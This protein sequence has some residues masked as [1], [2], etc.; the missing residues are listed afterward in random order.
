MATLKELGINVGVN[1]HFITIQNVKVPIAFTMESMEHITDVY[2]EDYFVFEQDL[3]KMLLDKNGK[4]RKTLI[5]TRENMKIMRAL[6][7][8][9][10]RTGGTETDPNE[11]ERAIP[12]SQ[13]PDIYSACMEVFLEQNFQESDVKKSQ[14]PQDF[15][16]SQKRKNQNKKRNQ[17]RPGTGTSM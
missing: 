8:S 9:M 6:I 4:Q 1:H 13:V 5:P 3:N 15:K 10:V 16:K 11:L 7:Y 14:K 17:K 12:F 2:G